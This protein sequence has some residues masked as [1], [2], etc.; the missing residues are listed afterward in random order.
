MSFCRQCRKLLTTSRLIEQLRNE[1]YDALITEDFDNC[2]VG[3]PFCTS[4]SM[5]SRS[6]IKLNTHSSGLSHLI[7]PRAL[8]PVCSTMFFDPHEFSIYESLI[9]ESCEYWRWKDQAHEESTC[10]LHLL[11]QTLWKELKL[12]H[13][14]RHSID[15]L[16]INDE[17][18][19]SS[20]PS[21]CSL[22]LES[23]LKDKLD[24]P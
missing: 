4:I 23:V 2:G 5:F 16:F 18:T 19:N 7:S 17:K 1:K 21:R 12:E 15:D 24:L 10:F 6:V 3:K 14:C 11:S 20:S 9:T 22:P 8:I 13:I